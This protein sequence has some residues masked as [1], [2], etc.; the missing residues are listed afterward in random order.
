MQSLIT[1]NIVVAS[2]VTSGTSLKSVGGRETIFCEDFRDNFGV[3]PGSTVTVISALRV[4]SSLSPSDFGV[5]LAL[6]FFIGDCDLDLERPGVVESDLLISLGACASVDEPL[7]AL[8][9][10]VGDDGSSSFISP[11]ASST[12]SGLISRVSSAI[13]L[14]V[15]PW[16]VVCCGRG[17]VLA[18][19]NE[20]RRWQLGQAVVQKATQRS[21]PQPNN[22]L[23]EI[24]A[25]T[26]QFHEL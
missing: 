1:W 15:Q 22:L 4:S 21:L 11:S 6:C 8:E 3:F 9:S 17:L 2:S 10:A 24:I 20:N 16:T 26:K 23:F 5:W 12:A 14:S 7:T 18:P 19:E 25:C 13:I